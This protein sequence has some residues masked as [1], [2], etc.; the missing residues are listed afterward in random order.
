VKNNQK[1]LK[2][3]KYNYYVEQVDKSLEDHDCEFPMAIKIRGSEN[4]SKWITLPHDLFIIIK[5]YYYLNGDK[6]QGKD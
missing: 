2:M 1:G 6:I 5:N 3:E 4:S